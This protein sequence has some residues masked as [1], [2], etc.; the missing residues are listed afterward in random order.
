MHSMTAQEAFA[1]W[2]IKFA[3][4]GSGLLLALCI[5]VTLIAFA[6]NGNKHASRRE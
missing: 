1:T 2:A 3:V 4:V 6:A 5:A